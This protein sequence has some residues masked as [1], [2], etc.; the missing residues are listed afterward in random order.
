MR[1]ELASEPHAE[2]Q[3][4]NKGIK[5]LCFGSAAHPLAGG[6]VVCDCLIKDCTIKPTGKQENYMRR[7]R[8]LPTS[9]PSRL[10]LAFCRD[11]RELWFH[12]TIIILSS[13]P[14]CRRKMA[15]YN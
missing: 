13:K 12:R 9:T 11:Q 6:E 3:A 14:V 15:T 8:L 10:R 5:E 4:E 7:M 1:S 2:R